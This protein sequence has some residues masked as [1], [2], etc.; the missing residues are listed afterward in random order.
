MGGDQ[1][2][3][4]DADPDA[5]Q[6]LR[7]VVAGRYG[8]DVVDTGAAALERLAAGETRIVIVGRRLAD[9]DGGELLARAAP[10]LAAERKTPVTFLLADPAGE[11]PDV[12]DT[13][14][15]VF[16]RL[17]RGMD[18]RRVGELV[19]LA[20]AKLPPLPPREP[21]P[22]LAAVVGE[23]ARAI[24][25][26]GE[27]DTAARA[28]IAAVVQLV[29]ADRARCLYCDDESGQLWSGAEPGEEGGEAGGAAEDAE[30]ADRTP[31]WS[32]IAFVVAALRA[33]APS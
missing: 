22:A 17:V 7:G 33:R 8:L 6:W 16:Y 30:D 24:G 2:L 27:P 15:P 14:I 28:A 23:Y 20:T 13:Q 3:L 12:D 26:E 21:D 18:P 5:R 32:G 9:M 29:G 10:Y 11:T 25:A 4:A 19:A 1:L 31:G